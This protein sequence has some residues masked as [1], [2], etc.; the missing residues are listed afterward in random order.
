MTD[1][2]RGFI[3]GV[4]ILGLLA[5][6]A[7]LIM[8]MTIKAHAHIPP[9]ASNQATYV[10]AYVATN[11][12]ANGKVEHN[13]AYATEFSNRED[14]EWELGRLRQ[15]SGYSLGSTT[16]IFTNI[17]LLV[18]Y[19]EEMTDGEYQAPT[20]VLADEMPMIPRTP[21]AFK[22]PKKKKR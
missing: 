10:V 7:I 22:K 9:C 20:E 15:T 5:G 3:K 6:I 18:A 19:R 11:V 1:F 14:A 12:H 4:A 21:E 2:E 17:R 13:R 16:V 8:A